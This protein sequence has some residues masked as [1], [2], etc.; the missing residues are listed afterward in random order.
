MKRRSAKLFYARSEWDEPAWIEVVS[1]EYRALIEG[2]DFSAALAGSPGRR[3]LDVGCGTAIFPALLDAQLDVS[4]QLQTDL[5]DV[6]AA[7]LRR[8]GAVL[9]GLQHFTPRRAIEAAIE[10][11]PERLPIGQFEY[12]LIWAIH[13]FTTVELDR[14]TAVYRHLLDLLTPGGRCWVYQLTADSSYQRL[15]SFYRERHPAQAR[16]MTSEDSERILRSLGVD[17]QIHPI[18][19][20]HTIPVQQRARL[21]NYLRK[22]VLDDTLPAL[23]YFAPLLPAFQRDSQF[24]FPQTVKLISIIRGGPA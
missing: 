22:C 12:D 15:H 10:Q 18:R 7:S 8:A 13:S 11:I 16:F 9:E 5:L 21:E 2:Y 3:L 17:F 20:E 24:R 19:T 6:S 23:D 4:I 1:A 14:M